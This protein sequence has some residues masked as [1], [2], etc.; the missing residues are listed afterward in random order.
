MMHP[1]LCYFGGEVKVF[2]ANL[3]WAHLLPLMSEIV[4]MVEDILHMTCGN[5]VH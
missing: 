3:C 4:L 2:F 1:H 5:L